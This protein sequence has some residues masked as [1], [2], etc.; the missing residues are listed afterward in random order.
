MDG[1]PKT[2]IVASIVYDRSAAVRKLV[3]I[4]PLLPL[5]HYETFIF[6][7]I[8]KCIEERDKTFSPWRPRRAVDRQPKN[9]DERVLEV[10][11]VGE[12]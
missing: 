10:G 1:Q 12:K 6:T 4:G 8:V 7:T 11:A 9:G 2:P 5:I 3:K